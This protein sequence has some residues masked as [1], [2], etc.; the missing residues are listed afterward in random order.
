[1]EEWILSIGHDARHV[2]EAERLVASSLAALAPDR[3]G[4]NTRLRAQLAEREARVCRALPRPGLLEAIVARWIG[5]RAVASIGADI[6]PL[7]SRLSQIAEDAATLRHDAAEIA[8]ALSGAALSDDGEEVAQASQIAAAALA[9]AQAALAL[10]Q[11]AGR[12]MAAHAPDAARGRAGALGALRDASPMK[13]SPMTSPASG[14]PA[15]SLWTVADQAT[16][17]TS[18]LAR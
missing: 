1:M 7:S 12:S 18:C 15:A 16:G 13:P 3:T 17:W 5:A 9:E 10:A 6:R 14:R 4:G 8:A 2:A 11:S